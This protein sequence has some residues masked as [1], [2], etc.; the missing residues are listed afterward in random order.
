MK[1]HAG[2]HSKQFRATV[3]DATAIWRTGTTTWVWCEEHAPSL[4]FRESGAVTLI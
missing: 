2:R 1:C 4:R 3:C